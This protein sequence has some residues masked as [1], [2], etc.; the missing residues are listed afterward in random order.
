[1]TT[2]LVFPVIALL[3]GFG[4]ARAADAPRKPHPF[5]PSLPDLSQKDEERFDKIIDD[6]IAYDIG[7]LKGE[8]GKKALEAFQKLPPEA[9]FALLRGLNRAAAFD[10]SCPAVVIGRRI[11]SILR[12]STD[13]QLLDF[14]RENIGAGVKNSRHMGVIKDLRVGCILRKREVDRMLAADPRMVPRTPGKER[15]LLLIK[16][17]KSIDQTTIGKLR[18]MSVKELA[19]EAELNRGS[20]LRPI[21]I[22]IEKREGDLALGTLAQSAVSY[23]P[24]IKDLAGTLLTSYL[25]RQNEAFLKKRLEDDQKQVRLA[26]VKAVNRKG[27]KLGGE[28]IERLKDDDIEVRQA[29]RAALVK[30]AK[31][32]DY[33]PAPEAPKTERDAALEQWQAWWAKQGK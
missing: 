10:D 2:K 5:A 29:A 21:L 30:L 19:Q 7:A 26:A 14:A 25:A 13:A 27:L 15:E 6:F 4:L 23:E 8:E 11:N 31:G 1:M 24:E 32:V 22:E 12:S 17:I 3:L 16:P 33:G 18:A 28:L 9:I 20:K